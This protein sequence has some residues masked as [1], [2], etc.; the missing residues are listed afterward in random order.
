MIDVQ[1][2]MPAQV[3][4]AL[5]IER[6]W[7]LPPPPLYHLIILGSIKSVAYSDVRTDSNR[8]RREIAA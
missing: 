7:T 6:K 4:L 5:R 2:E 3:S 1:D 8:F